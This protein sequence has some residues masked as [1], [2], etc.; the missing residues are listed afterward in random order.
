MI[1]LCFEKLITAILFSDGV[2]GVDDYK[3][4]YRSERLRR[5]D[6]IEFVSLDPETYANLSKDA[7]DFAK[8][9]VFS[10]DGSKP[11][12]DVVS[13]FESLRIHPQLR[14]DVFRQAS[15]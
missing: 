6:F 10:F 1:F 5:F 12:G 13:F 7:A 4:K 15:I 2:I 14:W 8:S 11:A 3:E 9:M